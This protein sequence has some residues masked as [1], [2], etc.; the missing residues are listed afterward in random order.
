MNLSGTAGT[1]AEK[2]FV[3]QSKPVPAL[4]FLRGTHV[5][6]PVQLRLHLCYA[7]KDLRPSAIH[8][9]FDDDST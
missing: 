3:V 1:K 8:I 7:D 9:V 6:Q 2:P 4:R 5:V